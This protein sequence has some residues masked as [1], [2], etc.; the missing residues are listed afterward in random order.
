MPCLTFVRR[1]VTSFGFTAGESVRQSRASGSTVKAT[2]DETVGSINIWII[3]HRMWGQPR[4]RSKHDSRGRG[5]PLM[6]ALVDDCTIHG[7]AHGTTV[8]LRYRG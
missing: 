8:C 7:R 1:T 3:D 6:E 5:V 4:A 2:I